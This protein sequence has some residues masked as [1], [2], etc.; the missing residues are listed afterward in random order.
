MDGMY[1]RDITILDTKILC[2]FRDRQRDGEEIKGIP[3]PANE[4]D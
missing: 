3:C 2:D 1:P 4:P